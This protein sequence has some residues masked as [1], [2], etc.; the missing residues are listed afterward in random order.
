MSFSLNSRLGSFYFFYFAALGALMPYWALY[1]DEIG[2]APAAIGVVMAVIQGMRIFA[3]SV[4]GWLADH[5]G[6]RMRVIRIAAFA[7]LLAFSGLFLGESFVWV[8]TVTAAFSFFWSAALPQFEA[9]TLIHLDAAPQHYSR[10]RVWGSVGFIIAVLAVG[11]LL[12]VRGARVLPLIV[13]ALF[14]AVWIA[15]LMAPDATTPREGGDR[16][17]LRHVLRQPAV[18]AVLAVCFFSQLAH[19]PYYGFFSLFLEQHG[20][21]KSAIGGLWSLGVVAEIGVFVIMSWLTLR[22]GLRRLLLAALALAALRWVLIAL[23]VDKI[24][25]L[26]A[27]QT[28]H[29]ASFGINHAVAV[30][31]VHRYFP[32]R[33]QGQGQALYSSISFGAGGALGNLLAGALW[34]TISPASVFLA[35]A[36][37]AFVAYCIAVIGIKPDRRAA[38]PA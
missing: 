1:L 28:L 38:S 6:R 7:A 15:A 17:R 4:W 29:L 24:S 34:E 27:A 21:S 11:P 31:L 32:G 8:L 14:A 37:A 23:Y 5:T 13:M 25:I 33:L 19:G 20:Y 10:I 3:P 22:F 18:W 16:L 30:A 35:A 36:I 2:F 26:L 9:A 12:D